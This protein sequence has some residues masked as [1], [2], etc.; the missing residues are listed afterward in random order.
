[1]SKF[2]QW[3]GIASHVL[4]IILAFFIGNW[5]DRRGRKSLLLLGLFGKLIYSFM[6]VINTVM[7]SWNVNMII[8]TAS[9]P[10]TLFGADVAIFAAC[11]AYISDISSVEERTFR[12]TIL[13][14]A[15]LS[16]M[17]MGNFLSMI[18]LHIIRIY[19]FIL[20]YNNLLFYRYS[21]WFLLV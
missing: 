14:A 6:I 15:Y 19:Y 1:M 2:H 13:D 18:L 9:I 8:Y 4:P 20:S 11:F 17:P 21:S 5:S 3:N 7:P 16:T 10:S 12:I